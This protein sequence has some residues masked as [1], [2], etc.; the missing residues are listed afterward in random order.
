MADRKKFS[1]LSFWDFEE[2]YRMLNILENGGYE[3]ELNALNGVKFVA[4]RYN[5]FEFPQ[6]YSAYGIG[7]YED[8]IKVHYYLGAEGDREVVVLIHRNDTAKK[9]IRERKT[10]EMTQQEFHPKKSLDTWPF[11]E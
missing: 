8:A 6:D 2:L 3:P 10:G 5:C 11:S 9:Y 4:Q 7:T 1:A